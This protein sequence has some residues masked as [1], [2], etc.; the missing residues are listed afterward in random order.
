MPT[1]VAV[2]D[3][4]MQN[5]KHNFVIVGNQNPFLH[6]FANAAVIAEKFS[7]NLLSILT[8]GYD[9]SKVNFVSFSLGSK[10]IAPMTSRLLKIKSNGAFVIPRIT[11]LDP[12]IVK[13]TELHMVAGA[14]LN[15]NDADF[16]MTVHTDCHYW[17]TKDTRGH[18]NFWIN[19]GCDQPMCLNDF[20]K[21][22]LNFQGFL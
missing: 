22:H 2:K 20:S 21:L 13:D 6:V 15:K 8:A 16:V 3:A 11:A 14:R 1:V 10:A 19:G 12:G 7:S 9:I 17:G 18:V 4:Y 5:G